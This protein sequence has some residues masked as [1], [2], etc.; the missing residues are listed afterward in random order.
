MMN[1]KLWGGRFQQAL[2]SVI[3]GFTESLHFDRRLY[4]YDIEGSIAHAK[5]LSHCGLISNE[6]E[7]IIITGLQEILK[8]LDEEKFLFDPSMEDIHM[9]IERRLTD[10]IGRVGGKL[11]TARSRNDQVSLDVRLYLRANILEIISFL[12]EFQKEIIEKAQK[13]VNTILPGYTHL[14]RAQPVSLAHYLLAYFEMT[15]RDR[16]R[17][18]QCLKRVSVMPLGSGALAGTG[19]AI[20]RRFVAKELG[21]SEIT[22]NSLDAVSDRDFI[23]EFLS[24]ASI[25]M[26]HFS[27][28]AEDI[29][30]WSSSEFSFIELSDSV[31]TGSSLM[32][33]KKNPDP[34]ELIRGKTGRVYGNLIT[35]L[36]VMK[37]L[38]L[39]Y[40]RDLQ[41]DKEPLFDTVDTI[42]SVLAVACVVLHGATFRK[43]VMRRAAEEGF[44]NATDLAEYLVKKGLPFRQAHEKAGQIVLQG[45]KDNVNSLMNLDLEAYKNIC[46]LIENDIFDYL[47]LESSLVT[48]NIPGGT[49][50][51]SVMEALKNA[52]V[53]LQESEGR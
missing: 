45:I 52:E 47:K 41:E 7:K 35:L 50:P 53:Y 15:K 51:K 33:Q 29:V 23:V 1:K 43:D 21:F 3:E 19:L 26:M 13:H 31:C 25:I 27:R 28:F 49:A 24:V 46:P 5:M 9:S 12:N 39:S 20:D 4:P 42:K 22:E 8:E 6:D 14:Q 38:P 48:K 10:K 40:N 16:E 44:L 34:M 37:A 36:T 2:N 17:L 32:P 18:W 30:L 11:H